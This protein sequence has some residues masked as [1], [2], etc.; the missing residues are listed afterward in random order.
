MAVAV[1]ELLYKTPRAELEV[2]HE[3]LPRTI[4]G[5]GA[6][7]M[8]SETG[9][10]MVVE[11]LQDKPATGRKRGEITI[12]FETAK[13]ING[14]PEPVIETV[15]GALA[16]GFSDRD[17]FNNPTN[18]PDNLHHFDGFSYHNGLYTK[19]GNNDIHYGVYMMHYT[20]PKT[21][22]HP[23]NG[24]EVRDPHWVHPERLRGSNVRSLTR[25]TAEHVLDS[26]IYQQNLQLARERPD[27]LVP[28]LPSSFLVAD[29]YR[30]RERYPDM[31]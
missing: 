30:A 29:T 16:E 22:I 6:W 25:M 13:D 19:I 10:V 14:R 26:G 15:K 18:L 1:E 3:G 21:G 7:I 23:Y 12:L 20:G 5:V 8:D 4:R 28:V 17:A 31:R 9:F 24:L 11:E 2:T 27:L